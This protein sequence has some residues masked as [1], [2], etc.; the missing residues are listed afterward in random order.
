[1]VLADMVC[2]GWKGLGGPL[3]PG[4]L[5]G[6]RGGWGG[7][8]GVCLHCALGFLL[9]VGRGGWLVEV[10][11]FSQQFWCESHPGVYQG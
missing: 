11:V 3:E 7:D 1:M 5:R 2:D 4:G 6:Y 10:D 9:K 8:Y